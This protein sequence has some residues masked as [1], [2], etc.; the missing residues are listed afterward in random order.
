MAS[1]SPVEVP[2]RVEPNCQTVKEGVD[3]VLRMRWRGSSFAVTVG[4]HFRTPVEQHL[5]QL[6]LCLGRLQLLAAFRV[7]AHLLVLELLELFPVVTKPMGQ[8][9]QSQIGSLLPIPKQR[10][11]KLRSC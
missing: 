1:S 5:V 10:I 7:D 6:A 8:H 3:G 2:C 11:H 9:F 4:L